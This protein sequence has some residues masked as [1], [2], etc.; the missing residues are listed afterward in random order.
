VSIDRG[1]GHP[2]NRGTAV[3]VWRPPPV[4]DGMVELASAIR[5]HRY[6]PGPGRLVLRCTHAGL[7]ALRLRSP[8]PSV[9]PA[10]TL[11][12][13]AAQQGLTYRQVEC[14]VTPGLTGGQW[15]LLDAGEE[16]AR[17]ELAVGD[18]V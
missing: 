4:P 13:E 11:E 9:V 12:V 5:K 3:P 7:A 18:A 16:V 2:A 14:E 17:G 6:L 8:E 1:Q 15:V 10:A